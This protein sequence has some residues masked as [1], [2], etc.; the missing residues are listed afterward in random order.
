[1][2]LGGGS[3]DNGKSAISAHDSVDVAAS[4]TVTGGSGWN[5]GA[6]SAIGSSGSGLP[7]EGVSSL[8]GCVMGS[9]S[10]CVLMVSGRE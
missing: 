4:V 10:C 1:M 3:D 6:G 8:G 7:C 2:A 9:D 5:I